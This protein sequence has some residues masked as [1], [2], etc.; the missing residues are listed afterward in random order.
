VLPPPD[1][2]RSL[3]VLFFDYVYPSFPLLHRGEFE[4]ELERGTHLS[5]V[6]QRRS[7]DNKSQIVT[8]AGM[9]DYTDTEIDQTRGAGTFARV[10][11]LVCAIASRWSGDP[12]VL[13]GSPRDNESGETYGLNSLSAGYAFFRQATP[14]SRTLFA[15]AGV[16]DVQIFMVSGCVRDSGWLDGRKYRTPVVIDRLL[17]CCP[18]FSNPLAFGN[19]S[20]RLLCTLWRLDRVGDG[21]QTRS[22]RWR[23]PKER[24]KIN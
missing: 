22:R 15:Q 13:S 11:L 17:T 4:R 21:D 18:P 23:A 3:I 8:G 24:R 9:T 20:S 12:R 1:L 5:Q 7:Q 10:V 14:W 19:V 16:W 2:L 6:L